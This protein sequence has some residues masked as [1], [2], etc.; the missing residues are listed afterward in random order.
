VRITPETDISFTQPKK[1]EISPYHK[2]LFPRE[3][4]FF[5]PSRQEYRP[6][7]TDAV[8]SWFPEH[9]W[10]AYHTKDSRGS[11]PGFPDIVFVHVPSGLTG[12]AELKVEDGVIRAE[13]AEWLWALSKKNKHVYLWR[14]SDE[15]EILD[16]V[17]RVE[18]WWH[19]KIT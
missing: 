4:G 1:S 16:L 2:K 12:F 6:G 14:P 8:M 17:Q 18:N 10:Y 7:F 15:A 11:K 19:K 13:Q 5:D 9:S 3:L